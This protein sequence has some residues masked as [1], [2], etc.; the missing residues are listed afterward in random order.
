MSLDQQNGLKFA[1]GWNRLWNTGVNA[2]QTK[3]VLIQINGVGV[4]CIQTGEM[5]WSNG[6]FVSHVVYS[7]PDLR[8]SRNAPFGSRGVLSSHR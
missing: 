2:F 3:V 1:Y 8:I 5:V 4:G 6:P 7:W